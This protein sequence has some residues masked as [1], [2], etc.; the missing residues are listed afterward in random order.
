MGAGLDTFLVSQDCLH[1]MTHHSC[2]SLVKTLMLQ[3]SEYPVLIPLV[4]IV[5]IFCQTFSFVEDFG[6]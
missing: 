4:L 2:I 6:I 1:R 5:L 3:D